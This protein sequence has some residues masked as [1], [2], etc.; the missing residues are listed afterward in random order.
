MEGIWLGSYLL[1]WA[2][3][4]LLAIATL[5]LLRLVGQLQMRLGPAGAAV[6]DHGLEIGTSLPDQLDP[7][8]ARD[9][10]GRFAFPRPKD[11]LLLFVSPA[12]KACDELLKSVTPFQRRYR[13]RVDLTLV[14]NSSDAEG[15]DALAGWAR[16]VRLPFVASVPL[17]AAARVH[18]TPFGLWLDAVGVVR[19]KGIVNHMEHL[20]SLRN[21]REVGYAS[22]DEYLDSATAPGGDGGPEPGA[23]A[24]PGGSEG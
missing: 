23:E 2:V 21:A 11:S 7:G 17:A 6:T 5:S 9:L 14:S 8:L 16:R 15:N 20:E 12:C 13:D 3:V 24:Q 19:A 4:A 10:D 18:G 22:L 1:L